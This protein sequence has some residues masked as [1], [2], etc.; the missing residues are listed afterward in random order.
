MAIRRKKPTIEPDRPREVSETILRTI[1]RV[2]D[3]DDA[4]RELKAAGI[5]AYQGLTSPFTPNLERV[6]KEEPAVSDEDQIFANLYSVAAKTILLRSLIEETQTQAE[7]FIPVEGMDDVR[8]A[9]SRV[10]PNSTPNHDKIFFPMWQEV[11]DRKVKQAEFVGS[12]FLEQLTGNDMQDEQVF[13]DSIK[14]WELYQN[15]MRDKSEKSA[16]AKTPKFSATAVGWREHV[17]TTGP[18]ALAELLVYGA[19]LILLYFLNHKLAMWKAPQ[20]YLQSK[21]STLMPNPAGVFIM[22]MQIIIGLA[23]HFLIEGLLAEE[24]ETVMEMVVLPEDPEMGSMNK[25]EIVDAA[26]A[27]ANG[28]PIP[29]GRF[30]GKTLS[31]PEFQEA[32]GFSQDALDAVKSYFRRGDYDIIFQYGISWLKANAVTPERK[33]DFSQWFVLPEVESMIYDMQNSL[34]QAPNFSQLFA[35]EARATNQEPVVTEPVSTSID[36]T[37][38]EFNKLMRRGPSGK[39]LLLGKELPTVNE[40]RDRINISENFD[41]V[42]VDFPKSSFKKGAFEDFIKDNY[43]PTKMGEDLKAAFNHQ[44][45]DYNDKTNKLA[46]AL[47]DDP[48]IMSAVCCLIHYFGAVDLKLLYAIRSVLQIFARGLTF[49]LGSF[50]NGIMSD[51][52]DDMLA[53]ARASL[54][55]TLNKAFDKVF[56]HVLEW[57]DSEALEFL[58]VCLPLNG[59]IRFIFSAIEELELS[60]REM[61]DEILDKVDVTTMT[62]DCKISILKEQKWAKGLY[63]LI[64]AIIKVVEEG[65]T[66]AVTGNPFEDP[67]TRRLVDA[68]LSN[69]SRQTDVN[70]YNRFSKLVSDNFENHVITSIPE[71]TGGISEGSAG[72]IGR[73]AGNGRFL[74]PLQTKDLQDLVL[75]PTDFNTFNDMNVF[76]TDNDMPVQP[77]AANLRNNELFLTSFGEGASGGA[78]TSENIESCFEDINQ[79]ELLKKVMRTV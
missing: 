48:W 56:N 7:L 15:Q 28:D 52:Y 22:I 72:E 45:C 76:Y 4:I 30:K 67:N 14:A 64:D 61:V 10:F 51:V 1:E 55:A 32:A 20:T 71:V 17:I 50:L 38:R 12:S 35:K 59:I 43:S 37:R 54:V 11:V 41:K 2:G 13:N 27:L 31:D 53:K 58:M 23:M 25:K 26:K 42:D 75:Q 77:V 18:D 33:E 74:K 47:T 19:A 57:L 6:N 66:C 73:G 9:I 8:K 3:L 79:S 63:T 34:E 78:L 29:Y 49:D 69:P 65:N 21:A 62:L 68:L 46:A 60:L 40:Q 5:P 70:F 36:K 39:P 16:R 24:V 44:A